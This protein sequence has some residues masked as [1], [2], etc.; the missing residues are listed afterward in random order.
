MKQYEGSAKFGEFDIPFHSMPLAGQLSLDGGRTSLEL[1][2]KEFFNLLEVNGKSIH[3]VLNDK[4]KISLIDC[5]TPE[6][7]GSGSRSGERYF[8]SNIFP[9]YVVFG[10]SHLDPEQETI[11]S[12]GFVIEDASSL[13]YDFDAF[14]TILKDDYDS[15]ALLEQISETRERSFQVGEHPEIFYFTGKDEVFSS[16]TCWGKISASHRPAWSFPS[17]DGI[18]MKN[19]IPVNIE[20]EHPHKFEE[21]VNKF[22]VLLGFLETIL[23][24]PQNVTRLYVETAETKEHHDTL[25]I[26][27]CM[28]PEYKEYLSDRKPHPADVLVNG[29]MAPD[30]FSSVLKEWLEIQSDRQESRA[31]FI[32]SFRNQNNYTIDRLVGAANMFDILPDNAVGSPK[33][34]CPALSR[35]IEVCRETLNKVPR[36]QERDGVLG[37]LGRVGNHNLKTR[38]KNRA[39]LITDKIDKFPELELVIDQTINCRNFYVHGPSK[40]EKLT[41]EDRSHFSIFFTDTLEFV[42][43]ASELIEVGWDIEEW[44][45]KGSCL[46]HPFARYIHSYPSYSKELLEKVQG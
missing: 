11:L 23:G 34:L 3:G 32:Q 36:T 14:G 19:N 45:S 21:A 20:F 43:A 37:A 31:R 30:K 7:P 39:K 10:D 13:F 27:W 8:F 9:H 46:S 28:R 29:G 40:K 17:P 24:Q 33:S 6:A 26:Y 5:V 18:S 42:F 38:V 16:D 2:S 44:V 35:A 25:E 22:Y 1:Y 15:K 41:A 12:L 4:E